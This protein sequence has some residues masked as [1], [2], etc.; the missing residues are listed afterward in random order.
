MEN[1]REVELGDSGI[2]DKKKSKSKLAEEEVLKAMGFEFKPGPAGFVVATNEIAKKVRIALGSCERVFKVLKTVYIAEREHNKTILKSLK[3]IRSEAEPK[4]LEKE[5]SPGDETKREGKKK[6]QASPATAKYDP[7][8]PLAKAS[9][10]AEEVIGK[11]ATK[12]FHLAN[13]VFAQVVQP[14][15]KVVKDAKMKFTLIYQKHH[16][17]GKEIFNLGSTVN[18]KKKESVDMLRACKEARRREIEKK[19]QPLAP[20]EN[21]GFSSLFQAISTGVSEMV[22]GKFDEILKST[23]SS[24]LQYQQSISMANRRQDKFIKKDL[25]KFLKQYLS[26]STSV[27]KMTKKSLLNCIQLQKMDSTLNTL[28]TE[29]ENYSKDL[30]PSG[31]LAVLIDSC[32]GTYKEVVDSFECK[33]WKYELPIRPLE[34]KARFGLENFRSSRKKNNNAA[35]RD[36]LVVQRQPGTKSKK[37]RAKTN[38][39]QNSVKKGTTMSKKKKE[40]E[41]SKE[42]SEE[43]Y[44]DTSK[45]ETDASFLDGTNVKIDDAAKLGTGDNKEVMGELGLLSPEE[46]KGKPAEDPKK[47]ALLSDLLGGDD[48]LDEDAEL[49]RNMAS[50]IEEG[51]DTPRDEPPSNIMDGLPVE[52]FETEQQ[53]DEALP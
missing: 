30:D 20:E 29:L 39:S 38:R 24:L 21:G 4:N 32:N 23:E 33:R 35:D 9:S 34:V 41:H 40:P 17:A 51:L 22:R 49:Q 16:S 11:Q 31:G 47:S 42:A 44:I 13:N 10:L 26:L 2:Q 46:K 37:P 25:P 3:K 19:N 27:I 45:L 50:A 36:F 18:A 48:N 12:R 53:S 52:T 28:V 8:D 1:L 6:K 43:I 5:V 14:L 15:G 7:I